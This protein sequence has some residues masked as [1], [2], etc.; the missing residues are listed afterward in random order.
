MAKKDFSLHT[1]PVEIIYNIMD[2]MDELN[3]I[4]SLRNVCSRLNLVID[5]YKRYE[6]FK[7]LV[8]SYDRYS[9]EQLENLGSVIMTNKVR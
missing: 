3:I 2:K 1:L 5:S 8:M 6:A 7:K 9:D 4:L